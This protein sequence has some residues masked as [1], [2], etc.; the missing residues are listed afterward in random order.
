[1][2]VYII[3]KQLYRKFMVHIQQNLKVGQKKEKWTLPTYGQKTDEL[4]SKKIIINPN[5]LSND[6]KFI[7][8]T[9]VTIYHNLH[10]IVDYVLRYKNLNRILTTDIIND[11]DSLTLI[12]PA[13]YANQDDIYFECVVYLL[14]RNYIWL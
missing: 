2:Q 9:T 12:I 6:Y 7:N 5:Q 13:E 10:G 11:N 4:V 8:R 3:I 14:S 1:M